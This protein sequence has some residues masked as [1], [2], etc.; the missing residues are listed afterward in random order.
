MLLGL[1][2]LVSYVPVGGD[3]FSIKGGNYKLMESALYQAKH[4]YGSSNCHPSSSK[5]SSS[6]RIQ[7]HQK[8]I[9]TVVS[10]ENSMELWSHQESL[11]KFDIVLLAAP[12][13][14]CRIHFLI[15]SPMDQLVLHPMPLGGMHEN[16]DFEDED[17]ETSSTS[18]SFSFSSSSKVL[19]NEHGELSF[20]PPLPTSATTPYTSVVTTVVSN[21]TFNASH[22]GLNENEQWPRSI[23][24]SERGKLLE[25]IT[26]L[27]ILS[28]DKGLVKTFSSEVLTLEKRNAL[29]GGNH[30]LEYVQ[31]WGGEG[32]HGG[33][34]PYFDG[35][36]NSE[37]LPYLLYDGAK[38]WGKNGSSGTGRGG[39]ALYYVNAIESAV[40]AIEISA[41]GAK[42]TA[43][44]VARRLGLVSPGKKVSVHEEL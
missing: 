30:V 8:Q 39:P 2:G 44:L 35:G 27:T 7:R 15:Q 36:R 3:L 20:P 29:F 10:D 19:N 38:H 5:S 17:M 21:V 26:T 22:F 32:G 34:T 25:E 6:S 4:L 37:S 28:I 33:A 40:A 12:L 31:M 41:I 43:K 1:V 14:Q 23:L 16:P 13:Q 9:T 18:S 11:G 42:S 24:V